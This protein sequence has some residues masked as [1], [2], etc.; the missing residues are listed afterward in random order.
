MELSFTVKSSIR[1]Q[2]PGFPA[3][4]M[5]ANMMLVR[6]VVR[7]RI[8]S[9]VNLQDTGARPLAPGYARYKVRHGASPVRNWRL[10]GALMNSM[11]VTR[12]TDGYATIGFRGEDQRIR[13]RF[14][15]KGRSY[16]G[17]RVRRDRYI[18]ELR[19]GTVIGAP[20]ALGP[21]PMFGLSPNDRRAANGIMRSSFF[22]RM[23][24]MFTTRK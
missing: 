23:A 11:D 6:D 19:G 2:N 8:L 7:A 12:A 9:G 5:R 18:D 16:K 3:A 13:A 24:D 20:W 15:A 4:E 14:Q 17:P 22:R 10:T 21:E 1:I